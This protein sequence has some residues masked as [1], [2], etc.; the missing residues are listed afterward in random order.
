MTTR[1]KPS[2]RAAIKFQV[3]KFHLDVNLTMDRELVVLFGPS[4]AGKSLLLRTLAGLLTPSEGRIELGDR[5]IFDPQR[6]INIPPQLRQVGYMPQQYA[7]FPHLTVAGNIRYGL[8]NWQPL[9][10]ES[11][12]QELLEVMRLDHVVDRFPTEISGGE[13]QRTALARALAPRPGI[14]LMDEPFAALDEVLRE[15]LRQELLR[16]QRRYHLP[17]LLVTHNLVEAYTLADRVVI[18][19][20][21]RITQEGSRDDVFRR[22]DTPQIAK[23]MAMDNVIGVPIQEHTSVGIHINWWGQQVLLEGQFSESFGDKLTIGIRPEDIMIVRKENKPL[24]QD[25]DI[26]FE[27]RITVDQARGFDH[28]LTFSITAPAS[29]E[30]ELIVRIPHPIFLRMDL[31]LE[32]VRTLAIRPS[33]VHI[34]TP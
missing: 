30:A 27:G 32:A 20:D 4:G 34:F 31:Q 18:F 19:Q 7:L 10:R 23:L 22:P 9:E 21:G 29:E 14:L 17:I 2:L 3:E 28:Q 8:F 13:Q 25:R 1:G 26:F 11:R 5:V 6:K 24:R 12:L 33:V 16:L 15:H